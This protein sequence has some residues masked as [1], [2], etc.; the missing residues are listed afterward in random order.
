MQASRTIESGDADVVLAGGVESM[1]RAPVGAAQAVARVPGRQRHRGLDD[2][3]LAAGQRA[4]AGGVDRLAGRGQRAA[5][6]P[7][8]RSRGS[9]RTS[10]PPARTTSPTR[11][12][13]RG[14]TTTWW[15]PCRASDL[16]RDESIRPGSSAETLAGLK[17]SFRP[18][19]T[20]T[21]GNASPLNDGASAVLL[22]SEARGATR[23]GLDPLA[24]IAGRGTFALAPQDFGYRAGRGGRAGAGP[25]RDHLGRRRRGRAQRGVRRP[26]ARLRRRLEGRPRD[27]QRQGRRDRDRPPARRLRRPDPRHPRR[28]GSA[29]PATGGASPRSASASAR[30]LAVV[31]ENVTDS[32][33]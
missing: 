7:V 25:G 27:R 20:I 16:A 21:A 1:T 23:I 13:T 19:G 15:C 32:V 6:R 28:T 9:G 10:S 8:R 31:L 18:D 14:S 2:A 12:G 3:G 5:R 17:P 22:G 4:D 11:P 29:S 26:V 24:R 30:R 33:S